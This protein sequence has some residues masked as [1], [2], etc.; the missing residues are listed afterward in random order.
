[1]AEPKVTRVEF[2]DLKDIVCE[3]DH[4]INGN[5][6]PCAKAQLASAAVQVAALSDKVDSVNNTLSE[7]IN[8]VNT[9]L[10]NKISTVDINLGNQIKEVKDIVNGNNRLLITALITFIS[11]II[12]MIITSL[13]NEKQAAHTVSQTISAIMAFLG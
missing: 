6:N 11:G 7:K 12:I 13:W 5:G 8:T 1:M 2:E 4:F 9:T 10:S 3:H